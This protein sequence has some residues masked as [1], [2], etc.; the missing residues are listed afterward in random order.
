ME[1][2]KKVNDM[3]LRRRIKWLKFI[4]KLIRRKMTNRKGET[5]SP[6]KTIEKLGKGTIGTA[7][8]FFL[9]ALVSK[10]KLP[11]DIQEQV[12]ALMPMIGIFTAALAGLIEAALNI[13][14]FFGKK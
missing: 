5:F 8:A 11:A 13:I 3:M 7:I 4:Y 9:I 2:S 12:G 1:M 10:G 14:K 6:A